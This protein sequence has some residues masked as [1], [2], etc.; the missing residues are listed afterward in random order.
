[1]ESELSRA[2]LVKAAARSGWLSFASNHC[3]LIHTHLPYQMVQAAVLTKG[4]FK[5][6]LSMT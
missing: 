1:M 5:E 2:A 3:T 6:P 4:H